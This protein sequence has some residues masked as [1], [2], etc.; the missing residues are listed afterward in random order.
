VDV[1]SFTLDAL[2]LQGTLMVMGS[3]GKVASKA[4]MKTT[5][6][7]KLKEL[8]KKKGK[9]TTTSLRK[10]E[11]ATSANTGHVKPQ[12]YHQYHKAPDKLPGFKDAVRADR[13]T[14]KQGGGGL[15]ER[16]K[17]KNFIYE[18]DSRHGT[19]EKYNKRGK[20]LGEYDP[21]TGDLLNPPDPTRR[22]EP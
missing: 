11:Q 3:E 1:A 7:S 16:W 5:V 2:T 19:I 21:K 22:I 18:W 6:G 8:A 13:K 12:G 15:R 17:D 4:L 9:D 14:P 20:H 10:A